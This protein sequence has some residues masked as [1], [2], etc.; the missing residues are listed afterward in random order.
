M[1]SIEAPIDFWF[2]VGSTYTYLSVMRLS[3]VEEGQ[4]VKFR[5]RPFWLRPILEEMNNVPF[6]NKPVK[7]AYMWRDLERR[8]VLYGLPWAGPAPYPLK[9]SSLPNR[10]AVLG[11]REGW[12]A[13]YVRGTY[14]RW[15]LEHLPADKPGNLKESLR[16]I[17]HDPDRVLKQAGSAEIVSSLQH[18][19]D[20]ARSLGIFGAPTF[21]TKGE[22]FWGDDRLDDA[23]RWYRSGS[24]TASDD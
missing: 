19:T 18:E 22:I 21:A 6:A 8:A 16:A 17:G 11:A 24:L 2:T 10:V 14:R 5:W 15:F 20:V 9:D 1:A 4:R 13:D 12:C 7:A 3:A 23:I